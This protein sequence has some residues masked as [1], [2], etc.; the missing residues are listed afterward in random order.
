MTSTQRTWFAV[1][2][3]AVV[4]AIAAAFWWQWQSRH[5]ERG[6]DDAAP[7]STAQ[8]PAAAAPA[9]AS[10]PAIRYPIESAATEQSE[11]APDLASTLADLF[12][13][14][15][16][17]S[18]FLLDEFPR[19]FVATVDNLGRAQ[20]TTRLWPVQPTAGRFTVD[21]A[22]GSETIGAANAARYAPFV[23]LVEAVDVQRAVAAYTRF[24]P[25]FQSAYA[26]LG[27]PRGYF[28]DRLVDVIDL[29]LATP[30]P[31]TA[32]AVHLAVEGP[33]P[34]QRPWVF[35]V[36]DDPALES[37]SSGQKILL[38]MGVANERRVKAKLTELR[39]QLVKAQ[40]PR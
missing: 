33:V 18:M 21:G 6:F 36:F 37:L 9:P 14:R 27:Y 20:A 12:G 5:A 15:A 23:A 29:L 13:T 2:S 32:P 38:R 26:E 30:E 10:A 8:A 22:A 4:V 25:S 3:A 35:Y 17:Q 16:V 7:T 40:T 31:A 11:A 1:G 24:Y 39:R 28:N 19:R 34:L